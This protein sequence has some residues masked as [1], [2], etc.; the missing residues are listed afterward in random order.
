MRTQRPESFIM[1]TLTLVGAS[2]PESEIQ[3]SRGLNVISG[4]SD[5]GK[6][7][8]AQCINFMLGASTPPKRI[9]EAD[10]YDT[11]RLKVET[12]GGEVLVLERS[13]YGGAFHLRRNGVLSDC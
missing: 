5:T 10:G 4:P 8:I 3:F 7:F 1:K 2:V 11:V 9:P 12:M 13:L 6:T